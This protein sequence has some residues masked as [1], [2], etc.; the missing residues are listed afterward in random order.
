MHLCNCDGG[1]GVITTKCLPSSRLFLPFLL[2][3][4]P[5]TRVLRSTVQ[6]LRFSIFCKAGY[7]SI[8]GKSGRSARCFLIISPFAKVVKRRRSR[9]GSTKLGIFRKHA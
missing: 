2:V 8:P 9:F 4:N 7:G 3:K 5:V 6:L 1:A